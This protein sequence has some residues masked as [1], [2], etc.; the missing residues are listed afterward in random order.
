M[1]EILETLNNLSPPISGALMAIFISIIRVIYD[2]K[3]TKPLRMFLE[4]L[5]CGALGLSSGY[6]ILALG[7]NLNWILFISSMIGYLGSN[8]V[9]TLVL[10]F[11]NSNIGN[12]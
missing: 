3:E 1:K 12:K 7:L 5:I 10:K 4:S 11:I 2:G 8:T 6:A 9:R